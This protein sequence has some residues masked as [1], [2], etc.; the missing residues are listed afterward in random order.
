[1]WVADWRSAG[2]WDDFFSSEG[3]I[4]NLLFGLLA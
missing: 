2:N 3:V 1:M 4:E